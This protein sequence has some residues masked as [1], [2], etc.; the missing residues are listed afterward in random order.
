MNKQESLALLEGVKEKMESM[1]HDE[2]FLDLCT[3]ESYIWLLKHEYGFS[4]HQISVMKQKAKKK[5]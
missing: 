5:T 1:S 3:T 2:L 4:T